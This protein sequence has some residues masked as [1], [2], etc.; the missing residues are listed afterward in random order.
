M[1]CNIHT[2]NIIYIK[3]NNI[4]L[5]PINYKPNTMVHNIYLENIIVPK[6]DLIYVT[7]C[8]I[9]ADSMNSDIQLRP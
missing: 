5:M 7:E 2:I 6:L 3:C 9:Y 4:L 1:V 8:Q